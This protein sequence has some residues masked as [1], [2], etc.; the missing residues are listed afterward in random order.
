MKNIFYF[1]IVTLV[2]VSCSKKNEEWGNNL[3]GSTEL[4]ITPVYTETSADACTLEYKIEKNNLPPLYMVRET[5]YTTGWNTKNFFDCNG[6]L[7]SDVKYFDDKDQYPGVCHN[8]DN[9]EEMIIIDGEY[10]GKMV[11]IQIPKNTTSKKR[12][13]Y[14][15]FNHLNVTYAQACI[16]QH[17]K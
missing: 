7:W 8:P 14:L 15:Y 3:F 1:F 17:E 6:K 2:F 16:L 10:L 13:F 9:P 12:C 4:K 5:E 11:S